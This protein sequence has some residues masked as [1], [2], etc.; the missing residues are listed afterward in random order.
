MHV[1][2][3]NPITADLQSS[4]LPPGLKLPDQRGFNRAYKD[5]ERRRGLHAGEGDFRYGA[6][7]RTP[8]IG[9]RGR[10]RRRLVTQ[11]DSTPDL[12]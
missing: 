1:A 5:W 4:A 12:D 6:G 2:H 9:S 10:G 8:R 7:E 3:D 11:P